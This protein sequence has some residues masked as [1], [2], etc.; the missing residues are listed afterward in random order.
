[1]K[2]FRGLSQ[3]SETSLGEKSH[4]QGKFCKLVLAA[5]GDESER[6]GEGFLPW[7]SCACL[8]RGPGTHR[9]ERDLLHVCCGCGTGDLPARRWDSMAPGLCGVGRWQ[10]KDR[11]RRRR[12][13]S[14]VAGSR[15]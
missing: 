6:G 2:N 12:E 1:M 15:R 14:Q 13:L 9:E 4:A 8:V 11:E 10:I 5:R 3:G 7:V